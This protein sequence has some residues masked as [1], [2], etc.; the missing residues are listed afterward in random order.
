M[1]N[2][3]LSWGTKVARS[4]LAAR[5]LPVMLNV[6]LATLFGVST[7]ALNQ[8]V[9]LHVVGVFAALRDAENV[10]VRVIE[11]SDRAER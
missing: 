11:R 3:N 7:K 5:G 1:A 4:I 2:A 6:D 10:Y 8:A 9:E